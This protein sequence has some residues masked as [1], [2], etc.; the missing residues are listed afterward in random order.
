[1]FY[2]ILAGLLNL[3][4]IRSKGIPK[5][6]DTDVSIDGRCLASGHP[7]S[8]VTLI[9]CFFLQLLQVQKKENK[10]KKRKLAAAAGAEVLKSN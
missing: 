8:L 2:I 3:N 4:L 6:I 7:R 9:R 10:K 1:M 5:T